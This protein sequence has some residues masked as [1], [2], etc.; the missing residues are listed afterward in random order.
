M[1]LLKIVEE[2][3]KGHPKRITHIKGVLGR[4]VELQSLYGGSLEV[5][6]TAAILHD[7]CKYDDIETQISYIKDKNLIHKYAQTQVVYHALAAAYYAK[8]VLKI[9]NE[10]VFEAIAFHIWGK[11]DMCIETMIIVV[12]DFCEPNRTIPEA[13]L[14]YEVAKKNLVD[15]Y[16]LS[17]EYTINYLIQQGKIPHQEQLDAIAFYKEIR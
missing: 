16:L 8:D 10:N 5:I 4:A 14:V 7:I 3:L 15:A 12:A 17:L 2:K 9:Q 6:K 1:D 13:K 11:I